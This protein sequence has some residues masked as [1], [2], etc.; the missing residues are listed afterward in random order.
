M[1][2]FQGINSASLC[3]LAGRYDN[4]IPTR[5]LAPID[6]LKIPALFPLPHPHTQLHTHPRITLPPAFHA[7]SVLT[8]V[9]IL[10]L[11]VADFF[12]TTKSFASCSLPRTVLPR[13]LQRD[14]V[15]LGWL[16]ATSYMSPNAVGGGGGGELRGLNSCRHRSPNKLWTF[17]S[18]FNLWYTA[19]LLRFYRVQ[20][21]CNFGMKLRLSVFLRVP[22]DW[23]S[24][25]VLERK[26]TFRNFK[27][28]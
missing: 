19:S 24:S 18:I 14:V 23:D 4:P 20:F 11:K 26:K 17:N 5:F 9:H 7:A 25:Q 16:T 12:R 27:L 22:A 8:Q 15:Y 28:F 21:M 2:R 13:G 3:S 10:Y 6:C 1:N